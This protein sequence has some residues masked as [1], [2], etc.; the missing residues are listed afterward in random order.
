MENRVHADL[1]DSLLDV[2]ADGCAA[3]YAIMHAAVKD[4]TQDL[5]PCLGPQ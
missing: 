5:A 2:A 3:I 1:F 4:R